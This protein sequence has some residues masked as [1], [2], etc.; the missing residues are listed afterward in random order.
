GHREQAVL[1]QHPKRI[2]VVGAYQS[3][4]AHGAESTLTRS[5]RHRIPTSYPGKG[6]KSITPTSADSPLLP[7]APKGRI[8][9]FRRARHVP[10]GISVSIS[11]RAFLAGESAKPSLTAARI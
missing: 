9:F 11:Y 8:P 4:I 6:R 3:G 1:F 5:D 7:W 10:E 2:L